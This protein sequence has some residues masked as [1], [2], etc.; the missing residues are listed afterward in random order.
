VQIYRNR[1]KTA[2]LQPENERKYYARHCPLNGYIVPPYPLAK[3][4]IFV[5]IFPSYGNIPYFLC[6][7]TPFLNNLFRKT[8]KIKKGVLKGTGGKRKW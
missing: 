2:G 1:I 3:K 8:P 7:H 6:G 4:D 5:L